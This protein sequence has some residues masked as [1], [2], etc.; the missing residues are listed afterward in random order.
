ME[1]PIV[2]IKPKKPSLIMFVLDLVV[3]VDEVSTLVYYIF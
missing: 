1:S 2:W 3:F